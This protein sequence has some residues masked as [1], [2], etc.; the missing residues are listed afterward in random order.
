MN[1][2]KPHIRDTIQRVAPLAAAAAALL[3]CLGAAPPALAQS[4][5]HRGE[6]GGRGESHGGG[7]YWTHGGGMAPAPHGGPGWGHSAPPAGY[8]GG[9]GG[10]PRGGAGVGGPWGGLRGGPG[11]D[12]HRYNGYWVGGRWYYGAPQE[13]AYQTPTYRPGFTPWRRGSFL[14]PAYQGFVVDD[15]ERFHLRRPPYGYHWVQV[16]GEFLLVS[17]STGLIFDVVTGG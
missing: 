16:G 1:T 3:A 2:V 4:H 12:Q 17:S 10:G 7:P 13:P 11:W 15:F 14:P 6:G 9:P 5:D 8:P